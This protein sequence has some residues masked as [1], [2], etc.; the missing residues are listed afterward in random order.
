[1]FIPIQ[2]ILPKSITRLGLTRETKAALVC[3]I[4]RKLAPQ[5]VHPEALKHTSP[6]FLKGNVLT[7]GVENSA[8]AQQIATQKIVLLK[9]LNKA[10][11]KNPITNIKTRMMDK[12]I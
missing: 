10:L 8:W 7:I 4:Y 3:E 12:I 1:M 2:K 6:K 5:L 9:T 11:G